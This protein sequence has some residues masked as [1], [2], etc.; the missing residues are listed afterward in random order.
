MCDWCE[1]FK[2][3]SGSTVTYLYLHF[4]KSFALTLFPD[5]H[6]RLCYSVLAE[7]FHSGLFTT[8][9][10]MMGAVSLYSLAVLL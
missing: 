10:L 9:D 1:F 7:W 5:D 4:C 2:A 8:G 6:G 3:V